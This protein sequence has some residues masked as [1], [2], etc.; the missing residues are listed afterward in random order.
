[1]IRIINS[2]SAVPTADEVFRSLGIRDGSAKEELTGE[3]ESVISELA[4]ILKPLACFEQYKISDDRGTLDLGFS[5]VTSR[6]LSKNLSGCRSIILI[7]ATVGLG[8]DRLIAKYS[9][10]SPSRALIMQAAGAEAVECLLDKISDGFKS[11]G[12]ILRPRF[13]CGYG[14]LPLTLQK[15]IF[16]ALNPQKNI[17]V[18]LTDSLLMTPTKSVSAII[19][20]ENEVIL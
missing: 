4:P 1:M 6:D 15:D 3:V 5:R 9:R 2:I 11:A 17:G 10:T 19:G 7:N 18:S 13:S 20:I 12:A 14:D 16:S 8:V